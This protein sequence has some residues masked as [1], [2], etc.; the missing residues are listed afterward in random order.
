MNKQALKVYVFY[1]SNHLEADPFA[2]FGRGQ[3]GDTVKTISL[4]CSGK[5][6][7]PYLIKAFETGA[8]G[9]VIV[10]CRKNQCRHFEGSPR[11]HKRAEAVEALLGEIG[12]D[13]GRMAVIEC[14]ERGAEGV[15]G[16]IKHF[17]DRVRHLPP[18]RAGNGVANEKEKTVA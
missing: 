18:L 12:V 6:D 5:I 8:D 17:I 11:A 15:D 7:V 10:A 13:P 1:C 3:E 16:E 14:E 4:P 9:V 2:G